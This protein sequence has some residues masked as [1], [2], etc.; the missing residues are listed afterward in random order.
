MA[1]LPGIAE[2]LPVVMLLAGVVCVLLPHL[3]KRY[4]EHRY[5]LA[6]PSAITPA[7]KEIIELVEE[8]APG[9]KVNLKR[10]DQIAFT[11]AT[12]YRKSA[13][14]IFAGLV[15][16][17]RRDREAAKAV[18]L[19]ELG[20]CR[21][22]DVLMV[23]AGSFFETLLNAW[24]PF[25]VLFFL[26]PSVLAFG[27]MAIA[28]FQ[29]QW[30]LA[31]QMSELNRQ[32]EDINAQMR[33]LG[34]DP[35]AVPTQENWVLGWIGLQFRNLFLVEIPGSIS[36]IFS[37]LV[38]TPIVIASPLI[39]T[40]C[41]EF[42]ADQFVV[43]EQQSPEPLLRGLEFVSP[44]LSRWTWLTSRLSHPPTRLRQ[45]MARYG[46]APKPI[47][48]V[49]LLFPLSY[50]IKLVFL[51]M[52]AIAASFGVFS[53]KEL[54]QLLPE[55]NA[56]GLSSLAPLLLGTGVVLLL[57]PRLAAVWEGLFC[58]ERRTANPPSYKEYAIA[59][60][61]TGGLGVAAYVIAAIA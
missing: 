2:L 1:V 33:A 36:I 16:M 9:I 61:I 60:T 12:G 39:A 34:L 3:R 51:N 47:L 18:L 43:S 20:H 26:I 15:K 23:G 7:I 56:T 8:Y 59:A 29:D 21:H 11:Y 17:W 35:V 57:Y 31:Q 49:L 28:S 27:W 25:L 37:L 24:L 54:M 41:A 40:W 55:W 5:N 46:R 45:W 32:A 44:K 48:V 38:F 42:N 58:K 52:R 4:V 13:I 30:Q 50:L 19:Y 14:A 22:G 53:F 6:F 10:G